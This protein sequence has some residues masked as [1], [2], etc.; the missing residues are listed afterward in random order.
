[1]LLERFSDSSASYVPLSVQN[2]SSYKQLYRAAKAKLKLRLKATVQNED[3]TSVPE[4]PSVPKTLPQT[5]TTIPSTSHLIGNMQARKDYYQKLAGMTRE[6]QM[7]H[8]MREAQLPNPPDVCWQICCNNCDKVMNDVHFNCSTCD[9]GDYDLCEACVAC[10]VTC[11]GEGHWLVK[12]SIKNG[13][14]VN[15][16]TER[17]PSKP[18]RQDPVD[19]STTRPVD[20]MLEKLAK[21]LAE[22]PSEKKISIPGDFNIEEKVEKTKLEPKR[23]CNACVRGSDSH[24]TLKS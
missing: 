20:K 24:F 12:C 18:L 1:M 9:N 22:K 7:G 23:T 17:L 4:L 15:S 3:Y 16:T 21:K 13:S 8:R 6:R 19:K 10:G 2:P 11:S 5:S 14:I